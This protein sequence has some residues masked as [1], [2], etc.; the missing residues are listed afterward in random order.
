MQWLNASVTWIG[1]ALL[2][3]A[4]VGLIVWRRRIVRLEE[5]RERAASLQTMRMLDKQLKAEFRSGSPDSQA[6][7]R[8]ATKN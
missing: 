7:S 3:V 6:G 2:F 8:L 4:V 1:L 5:M